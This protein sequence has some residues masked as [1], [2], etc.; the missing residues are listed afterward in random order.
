[1]EKASSAFL[2]RNEDEAFLYVCVKVSIFQLNLV[3]SQIPHLFEALC[4]TAFTRFLV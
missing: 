2:N 1:M 3:V 4:Q